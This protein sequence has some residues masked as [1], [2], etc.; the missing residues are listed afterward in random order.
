MVDG[1]AVAGQ[2]WFV[3]GGAMHQVEMGILGGDPA[4]MKQGLS[5]VLDWYCWHAALAAG[6]TRIEMGRSPAHCA[7]GVFTYKTAWGPEPS[8]AKYV[9]GTRHFCAERLSPALQAH[10]NVSSD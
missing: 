1:A 3:N 4:L 9:Y 6:A 7:D 8:R 2:I 10:I 5:H